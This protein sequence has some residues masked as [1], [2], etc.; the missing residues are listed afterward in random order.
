MNVDDSKSESVAQLASS[1]PYGSGEEVNLEPGVLLQI[2]VSHR[3]ESMDW[4]SCMLSN[5]V[6]MRHNSSHVCKQGFFCAINSVEEFRLSEAVVSY[7]DFEP[8]PNTRQYLIAFGVHNSTSTPAQVVLLGNRVND[9]I[10]LTL[11]F[12]SHVTLLTLIATVM[13]ML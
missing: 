5:C 4:R 6:F 3:C 9:A 2:K 13:F 8:L 11:S 10:Q 7:A 12:V 1:V